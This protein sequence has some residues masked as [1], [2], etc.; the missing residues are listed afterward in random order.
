MDFDKFLKKY[1]WDDNKTPYLTPA[2]ALTREQIHYEAGAYAVFLTLLFSAV[3]L[4]L[5]IGAAATPRSTGGALYA[6]SVACAG[7][8]LGFTRH[9]YAALYAASAPLATVLYL[10]AEGLR[11]SWGTID[12]V[13]VALFIG[14]W[15]AYSI[16]VL[17]MTRRYAAL[18]A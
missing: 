14:A 11:P 18:N 17:R 10:L 13:F 9:Q 3:A 1:V 6:F 12:V 4:T 7:I 15:I 8:V 2:D 5:T 16:R